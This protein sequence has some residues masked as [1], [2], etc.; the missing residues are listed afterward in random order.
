MFRGTLHLTK[1]CRYISH[2][3]MGTSIPFHT[4]LC[5]ESF[6][7][8]LNIPTKH[9]FLANFPWYQN[10]ALSNVQ[11]LISIISGPVFNITQTLPM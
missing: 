8:P 11:R 5:I 2:L 7:V 3:P 4:K 10:D 6:Y 9:N 1:Q